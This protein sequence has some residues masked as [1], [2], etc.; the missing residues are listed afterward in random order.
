MNAFVCEDFMLNYCI[1]FVHYLFCFDLFVHEKKV[2]VDCN[3]MAGLTFIVY[4]HL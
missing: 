1:H 2:L 3:K 4:E